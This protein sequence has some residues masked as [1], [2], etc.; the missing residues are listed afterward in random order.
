MD[1]SANGTDSG[2]ESRIVKGWTRFS[3][4]AARIMYMNTIDS[5]KAERN[6]PNVRSSSRPRPEAASPL[7]VQAVDPRGALHPVDP[8]HAVQPDEASALARHVEPPDDVRVPA[9]APPPAG[10]GG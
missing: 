4:W 10:A 2:S 1:R 3:N 7:P 6:S 5:A 8:R 9:G